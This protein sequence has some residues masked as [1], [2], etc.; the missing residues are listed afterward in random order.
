MKKYD[1]MMNRDF[2][3]ESRKVFILISTQIYRVEI[4][5]MYLKS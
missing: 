3:V 2:K 1:R 5:L 4:Y